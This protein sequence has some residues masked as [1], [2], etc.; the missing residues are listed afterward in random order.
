MPIPSDDV[1]L[2]NDYADNVLHM[3]RNDRDLLSAIDPLQVPDFGENTF[4][5]TG[6]QVLGLS[7][8]YRSGNS[9]VQFSHDMAIVTTPAAVN[10]VF[11]TGRHR[12]SRFGLTISG[13]IEASVNR[14]NTLI[15]YRAPIKGGEARLEYFQASLSISLRSVQ[16]KSELQSSDGTPASSPSF[17]CDKQPP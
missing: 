16:W 17:S 8:F 14:V 10:D 11:F 9:T 13:D 7:A 15:V 2:T 6:G 12:A 3:M 1:A 4:Q 5:I